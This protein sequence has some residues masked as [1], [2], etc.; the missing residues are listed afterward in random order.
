MSALTHGYQHWTGTSTSIWQRRVAIAR[1]GLRLCWRSRLLKIVFAIVWVSALGLLAFHF[2][3]GQLLSPESALLGYIAENF[4]ERAKAVVDGLA[5]WIL[6]YPDVS[7]DGL[8]RFTFS[9]ASQLY[10]AISFYAVA[11]FVPKLISHDLSSRAILVYN[12]KALS[13]FDYL[14]GKFG[15]VFSLLS[16]LT[17]A[18]LVVVWFLG[19]AMSPDW[20]FFWHGFP[21]LVTALAVGLITVTS[22]GLFALAVSSLAKRT[23]TATAFWILAWVVSGFVAGASSRVFSWGRYL[24]PANCLR[25]ISTQLYNVAG[26]V[27][28]AKDVLPFFRSTLESL[29]RKSSILAATPTESIWVPVV[30]LCGFCA[31]AL[32][33]ISKRVQPE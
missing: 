1:Q 20:S 8:Y 13:R 23:S 27:E 15:I 18:P 30:F 14:L 22:I 4:G 33:A 29:P 24:S 11:L 26:V 25:E 5:A 28:H 9:Y 21:A 2:L 7:V 32:L 17:I 10:G 19:N 16:A 12:S 3:V 6:L 31:L